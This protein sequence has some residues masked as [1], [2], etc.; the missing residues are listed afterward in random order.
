MV[1]FPHCHRAEHVMQAL[2]VAIVVLCAVLYLTQQAIAK[3]TPKPAPSGKSCG[4]CSGCAVKS[5]LPGPI[6]RP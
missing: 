3:L 1:D 4:G 6:G 2:I 5:R